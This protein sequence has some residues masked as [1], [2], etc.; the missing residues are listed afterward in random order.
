MCQFSQG[1]APNYYPNS[2]GGPAGDPFAASWTPPP[3][4]FDGKEDY[5]PQF[6]DEDNYSQPK[7]FWDKVLDDAAK[8]R[9]VSHFFRI[10]KLSVSGNYDQV[11]NLADSIKLAKQDIQERTV[12]VFNNVSTDLGARLRTKLFGEAKILHL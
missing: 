12:D 3:A 11:N 8:N 10:S 2:F 6:Y 1:G 4:R 7:V 5:Y 9:L